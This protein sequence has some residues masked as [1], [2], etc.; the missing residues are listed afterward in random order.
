MSNWRRNSKASAAEEQIGN[1]IWENN[2]LPLILVLIN[3]SPPP[4]FFKTAFNSVTTISHSQ[5]HFIKF[6]LIHC[7]LI[8]WR[9]ACLCYD[10]GTVINTHTYIPPSPDSLNQHQYNTGYNPA[11]HIHTSFLWLINPCQYD[12]NYNPATHTH[13]YIHTSFPWLAKSMSVRYWLQSSHTRKVRFSPGSCGLG[14]GPSSIT[15]PF[16]SSIPSI[17]HPRT[18]VKPTCGINCSWWLYF[19]PVSIWLLLHYLSYI[20]III[21]RCTSLKCYN[22]YQNKRFRICKHTSS[23]LSELYFVLTQLQTYTS[24]LYFVLAHLQTYTIR[25]HITHPCWHNYSNFHHQFLQHVS[26]IKSHAHACLFS[27]CKQYVTFDANSY[28]VLGSEVSHSKNCIRIVCL[29]EWHLEDSFE[30]KSQHF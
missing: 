23:N 7:I 29:K 12:T 21:N 13:T 20:S 27:T 4:P 1:H 24:E 3:L 30:N 18:Y 10:E 9:T 16:W 15:R 22:K 25:K 26:N 5:V 8:Q 28:P 2:S 19:V 17:S 11:T 14:S 6:N